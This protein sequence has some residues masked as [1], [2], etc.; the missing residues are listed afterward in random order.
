MTQDYKF[1][2]SKPMGNAVANQ[3]T[4]ALRKDLL[5]QIKAETQDLVTLWETICNEVQNHLASED[6]NTLFRLL[7][8]NFD[9]YQQD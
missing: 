5:V 9:L 7:L 6:D 3:A 2:C 1:D 8:P 4:T